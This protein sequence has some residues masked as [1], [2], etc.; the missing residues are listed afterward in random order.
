MPVFR[1][2]LLGSA[3]TL[4]G[5][6]ALRDVTA[7]GSGTLL[8]QA[9]LF[10]A[11]PVFLRLYQ[12][13]D[14]GLYSFTYASISLIATLG[15]WKIE[16][17]IVVVPARATAVRLLVALITIAAAAA[18]LFLLLISVAEAIADDL[19]TS[20]R[21]RLALMWPAPLSMF[22]LLATTGMRFYSV[23]VGRFRTIAIAQ[24]ARAT[25]FA[26]GIVGTALLWHGTVQHGALIMISWQVVADA[27]ALVVQLQANRE[28][29]GLLVSRPRI[30]RSLSVLKTHRATLGVL[31][32]SQI[33]SSV[34]QQIPIT[35]VMLAFGAVPAG[36][37]SLA[38]QFVYAPCS[39]VISAVSDVV[40]QRL[41]RLHAERK[42]FSHHVLRTTL[43]MALAG[44]VPFALIAF[45]AP[46]LL[47]LVLGPHW[48]GASQSVSVLAVASYLFLI[49][50]PAGNV[51]LIVRARRY[52][53]LWHT[54]RMMTLVGL[55]AAALL[56]LISY[57]VWLI[58]MVVS[59][60]FLYLL[61]VIAELAFARAAESKWVQG[62]TRD[63]RPR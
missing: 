35:T 49:E 6:S 27:C 30:R 12:P 26:G 9:I 32:L 2:R 23:R 15:T 21:D 52:M 14:L 8:A 29:V 31:A 10:L 59:D 47:P 62:G 40:N 25:V 7:L 60:G 58:L 55:A 24:V 63:A 33:I 20:V 16:R 45:L 3:L 22:I 46:T 5:S 44:I 18:L 53:V 19:P 4:A 37:Y 50:A 39:I 28:T 38:T 56:S 41:S 51:A 36:W 11:A 34:N 42:P 57:E 1:R 13:S 61:D 17:L 54:A 48:V 43:G